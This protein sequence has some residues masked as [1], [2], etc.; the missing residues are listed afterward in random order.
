MPPKPPR[1]R[2]TGDDFRAVVSRPAPPPTGRATEDVISPKDVSYQPSEREM[3]FLARLP[4]LKLP[5]IACAEAECIIRKSLT[6]YTSTQLADRQ[7]LAKEAKKFGIDL[8][9]I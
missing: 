5:H 8:P 3:R 7:T 6:G 2:R 9:V 1:H 4:S